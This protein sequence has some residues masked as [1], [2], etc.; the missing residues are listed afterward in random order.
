VWRIT[1]VIH[2]QWYIPLLGYFRRR[3]DLAIVGLM[4]AVIT[5]MY[6]CLTWGLLWNFE[7]F[8]SDAFLQFFYT[9]LLVSFGWI[10][11]TT[12]LS[13]RI[14]KIKTVCGDLAA[15]VRKRRDEMIEEFLRTFPGGR[16]P[17]PTPPPQAAPLP[18]PPPVA[19]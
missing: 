5:S 7:P 10:F 19:R 12:A 1:H 17:I 2:R 8:K 15:N 6:F 4:C 14:R 11:I 9:I 3:A 16:P 18:P 13:Y